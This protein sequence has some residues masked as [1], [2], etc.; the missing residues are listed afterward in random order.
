MNYTTYP[1]E[2]CEF[3][4]IM[5]SSEL[6]DGERVLVELDEIPIV[7]FNIA[8]AFYAV[9]DLCPHANLELGSGDLEGYELVCA[10]HGAKFDV[11]SGE[12]L[13]LPAVE[14]I[15]AYPVRVRNG[16]LELGLPK[17]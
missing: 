16:N 10:Y 6:C 2:E 9:K 3:Y 8:D 4:E 13:S 17:G 14:A 7:I 5:P 11:R 15:P 1:E 12:V